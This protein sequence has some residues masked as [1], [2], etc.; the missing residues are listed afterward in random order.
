MGFLHVR[1]SQLLTSLVGRGNNK[2]SWDD[3]QAGFGSCY[4][5]SNGLRF[6]DQG[7]GVSAGID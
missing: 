3:L 1:P 6:N 2:D 5:L 7:V 4:G